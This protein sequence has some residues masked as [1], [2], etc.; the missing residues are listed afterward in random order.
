MPFRMSES[1]I[2]GLIDAISYLYE[3]QDKGPLI[4]FH[5]G[6]P[7]L[8]GLALFESLVKR[9]LEQTPQ[10]RMTIQSNGTIYN[11]SLAKMLSKFHQ[12]LSF[13]LSVDGFQED[14]DRHRVDRRGSSRF[15]KIK[16]TIERARNSKVLNAI[17]MVVDTNSSPERILEFMHWAGASQYDL[18]LPDGDHESLPPMKDG[19]DSDV[20]AQWVVKFA[21]LYCEA[22]RPFGVRMLDDL[23]ERSIFQKRQ[24][25]RPT[26]RVQ[27]VDLTVDTD[28]EIKLVDTLRINQRG[29][30]F[31]GGFK[32]SRAGIDAVLCASELSEFLQARGDVAPECK[33]CRY[34]D[35]CGGGFMQH[36]WGGGSYRN[37]SIYCADYKRL[38]ETF[39]RAMA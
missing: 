29:S 8:F 27:T 5:G 39:E 9:I 37:P 10:A 15:Q 11:S 19:L 25:S 33:S 24:L 35:M 1:A 34:F 38:F 22:R 36:R 6:E 7:L 28:G 17:L 30:D 23:I 31:A 13:S 26:R 32:I 4:A 16:D 12:S 20:A 3:K 2:E 18:L 21:N 14:N